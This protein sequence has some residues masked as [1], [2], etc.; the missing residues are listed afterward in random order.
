[1]LPFRR[2]MRKPRNVLRR[3]RQDYLLCHLSQ[4]PLNPPCA[5]KNIAET[6]KGQPGEIVG[7]ARDQMGFIRQHPEVQ[8]GAL[9]DLSRREA[10]HPINRSHDRRL[11]QFSVVHFAFQMTGKHCV[12]SSRFQGISCDAIRHLGGYRPIHVLRR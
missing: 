9:D 7:G 11:E 8:E 3:D 12:G 10:C 6:L 2:V 1:M 4:P 5:V